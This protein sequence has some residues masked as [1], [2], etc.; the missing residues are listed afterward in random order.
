MAR[1]TEVMDY[2]NNGVFVKGYR[3]ALRK[4][5]IETTGFTK[6]SDLK[7]TYKQG[8]IIIEEN[9]KL[10]RTYKLLENLAVIQS[11]YAPPLYKIKVINIIS[12]NLYFVKQN[13]VF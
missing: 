3:I 5:G 1:L 9:K 7:I 4:K 8:K 12:Q 6:E 2:R 13:K 11:L 10:K